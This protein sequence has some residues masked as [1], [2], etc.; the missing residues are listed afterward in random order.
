M[1][2]LVPLLQTGTVFAPPPDTCAPK[3]PEA[4]KLPS[5]T[6]ALAPVTAVNVEYATGAVITLDVA[7]SV[8]PEI[9]LAP[10]MLPPIFFMLKV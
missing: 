1:Y 6:N 10:E 8:V 7:L 4:T 2:Q 3:L 9:M 5:L